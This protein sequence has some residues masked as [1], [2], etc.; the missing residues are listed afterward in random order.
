[1]PTLRQASRSF[2]AVL[3]P[4]RYAAV[5]A[6]IHA[7]AGA[8]LVDE[9]KEELDRDVLNQARVEFNLAEKQASDCPDLSVRA[10]VYA[11]PS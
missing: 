11:K 4:K 2:S 1:M 8:A 3:P 9:A 7:D 6:V 10:R 5:A